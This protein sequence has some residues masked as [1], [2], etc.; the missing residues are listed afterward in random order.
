MSK[1]EKVR[2]PAKYYAKDAE[3]DEMKKSTKQSRARHFE[4]GAKM[5]DDN[6]PAYKPA[7]GR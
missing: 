7:L 5:D 6:P 1:T 4:K 2:K 3:G